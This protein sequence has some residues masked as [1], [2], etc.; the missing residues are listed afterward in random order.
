MRSS[1]A[2]LNKLRSNTIKV[3]LPSPVS[4]FHALIPQH[5]AYT[6]T[7]LTIRFVVRQIIINR[8]PFIIAGS[9]NTPQRYMLR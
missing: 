1:G 8:K 5:H 7:G 3:Y 6:G 4:A 9:A 2:P